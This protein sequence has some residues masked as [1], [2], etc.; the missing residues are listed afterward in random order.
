[1]TRCFIVG[2]AKIYQFPA[3]ARAPRKGT[4]IDDRCGANLTS[5]SFSAPCGSACNHE[6]AIQEPSRPGK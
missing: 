2:S 5:G 6:A 3:R 4:A 1:M